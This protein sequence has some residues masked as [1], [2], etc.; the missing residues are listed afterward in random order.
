MQRNPEVAAQGTG[1][2]F[3]D[4]L[5]TG[6]E[7]F[8]LAR[9]QGVVLG[10]QCSRLA[11]PEGDSERG[12]RVL[13]LVATSHQQL[14]QSTHHVPTKTADPLA[15]AHVGEHA[16]QDG[17][18]EHLIALKDFDHEGE[19]A[20]QDLADPRPLPAIRGPRVI[21][22]GESLVTVTFVQGVKQRILV[23]KATIK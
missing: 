2:L 9:A 5:V 11:D 3:R 21:G 8:A 13:K 1:Q 23:A 19:H 20:G 6:R 17:P 10:Q 4:L 15:Y 7:N 18:F 22:R 12:V 16:L 14:R